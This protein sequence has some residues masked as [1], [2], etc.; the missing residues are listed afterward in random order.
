VASMEERLNAYTS[1]VGKLK[2]R[3]SLGDLGLDI[4]ILLQEIL[5]R[6]K[7][8]FSFHTTWTS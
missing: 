1:L 8:Q 6:T 4:R 2:V 5:G 3:D 7:R